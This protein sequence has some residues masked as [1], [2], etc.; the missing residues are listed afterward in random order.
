MLLRLN[1][2]RKQLHDCVHYDKGE[3]FICRS[4]SALDGLNATLRKASPRH[5]DYCPVE[6][7]N[8]YKASSFFR[9]H[10]TLSYNLKLAR[11]HIHHRAFVL[12]HEF[13]TFLMDILS[14]LSLEIRK[15]DRIEMF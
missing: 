9:V 6:V 14:L 2:L 5:N 1:N 3:A 4:G 13:P 12:E 8:L 15:S 11:K 10:P 7:F